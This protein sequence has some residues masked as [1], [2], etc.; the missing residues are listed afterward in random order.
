MKNMEITKCMPVERVKPLA[1]LGTTRL[2]GECRMEMKRSYAAK[3]SP[4]AKELWR[5]ELFISHAQLLL[6][7][8]DEIFADA[9]L[10]LTPVPIF[11]T[12]PLGVIIDW[13]QNYR[14]AQAEDTNGALR[15]IYDW[16]IGPF[17]KWGHE[18]NADKERG[19]YFIG[20]DHKSYFAPTN[21]VW[22]L[23]NSLEEV[24]ERYKEVFSHQGVF[25]L[26]DAIEWL[27]D[28]TVYDRY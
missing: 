23:R 22:Q 7:C 17:K 28:T 12:T 3:V 13:W 6:E 19:V 25:D 2:C 24:R 14:C 1:L 15:Y 5:R 9:R 21:E 20:L 16:E 8:S 27:L 26:E 10:F 11:G 18:C 4:Q